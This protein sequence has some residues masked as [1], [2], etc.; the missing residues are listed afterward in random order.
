MAVQGRKLAACLWITLRGP[1]QLIGVSPNR[2]ADCN[3]LGDIQ[4]PFAKLELRYERLSRADASGH[5]GLAQ[6]GGS[7]GL[8]EQADYGLVKVGF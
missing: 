7:A 4:A 8:N 5:L 3:V 2:P 6:P 1:Q